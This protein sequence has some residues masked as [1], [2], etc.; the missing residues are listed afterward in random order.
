M[1]RRDWYATARDRL[2]ALRAALEGTP[3]RGEVE[4]RLRSLSR[5]A[6]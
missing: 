3:Y 1:L 2:P 5:L 6:S 4:E